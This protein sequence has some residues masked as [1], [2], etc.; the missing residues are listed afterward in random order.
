[1]SNFTREGSQKIKATFE[2]A[3][4]CYEDL[5]VDEDVFLPAN[6]PTDLP[7]E[8]KKANKKEIQQKKSRL[9]KKTLI[10]VSDIAIKLVDERGIFVKYTET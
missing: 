8:E 1:M 7:K 4:P 3:D 6:L 9:S 10:D 2:K 5:N